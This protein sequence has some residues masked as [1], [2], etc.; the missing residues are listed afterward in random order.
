[1]KKIT[2]AALLMSAVF[3]AAWTTRPALNRP[4]S[5]VVNAAST[6]IPTAFSSASG[7]LVLQNLVGGYYQHLMVVNYSNAPLS[8]LTL[9]DVSTAPSASVTGQRLHVVSS[10]VTA[11]DDISVFD[12]LYI[13]SEENAVTTKKVYI[14]V[15]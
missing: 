11:F 15:W 9:P 7:S 4:K 14:T 2:F 1:M 12:N 10:G 13:Q 5:V 8:I 3:L 6:T